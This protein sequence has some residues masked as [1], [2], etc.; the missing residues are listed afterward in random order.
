MREVANPQAQAGG[1]HPT[2]DELGIHY[3]SQLMA[4]PGAGPAGS[5]AYVIG[6]DGGARLYRLGD[7]VD[8]KV[9]LANARLVKPHPVN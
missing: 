3:T 6:P 8:A 9:S 2:D 1:T 4:A 5:L 7:G